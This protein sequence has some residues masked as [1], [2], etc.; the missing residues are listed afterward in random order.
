MLDDDERDTQRNGEHSE[1]DD[2]D[3]APRVRRPAEAGEE[4]D[5]REGARQERH[6]NVVDPVVRASRRHAQDRGDHDE[7]DD[8]ERQVDVEDPG[9]GEMVDE[10]AADQG[11]DDGRDAEHRSHQA[12]VAPALARRNDVADDRLRRDHERAAAEP[13]DRAKG[14]Q[15]GHA[16]RQ[17]A[18]AR[19]DQEHDERD[20]Q[21]DLPA[22]EIAELARDRRRDGRGEQICRDDPRELVDAAQV[23]DDRRQR[24][25]DDRRV[26]RREQ[27]HEH[28]RSEDRSDPLARARARSV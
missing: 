12:A 27:H 11:P 15:L 4:H 3:R 8:A 22:V 17:A 26:E 24:R 28:Q 10:E 21:H 13:L 14:D 9:P 16:V 25:R 7:G 23:P 19:A 20:L 2:P 1:P 6:P 5:R 18:Q